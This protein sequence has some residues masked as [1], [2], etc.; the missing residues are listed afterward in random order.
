MNLHY[1]PLE[2]EKIIL[3]PC[4]GSRSMWFDKFNTNTIY[5]DMRSEKHVLCDGYCLLGDECICEA[6]KSFFATEDETPSEEPD[7]DKL[8]EEINEAMVQQILWSGWS[9]PA[10]DRLKTQ[11]TITRKL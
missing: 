4:C 7:Q 8:W 5:G 9:G 10:I 2:Q 1:S 11:Y 3:D 6:N